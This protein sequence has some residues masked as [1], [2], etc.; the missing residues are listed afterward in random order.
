MLVQLTRRPRSAILTIKSKCLTSVRETLIEQHVYSL[1]IEVSV[2][3]LDLAIHEAVPTS[4][5]S[6][7]DTETELSDYGISET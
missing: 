2:A 4:T 6:V 5:F 1:G 7:G 3:N